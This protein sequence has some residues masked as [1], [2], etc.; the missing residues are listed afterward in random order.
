MAQS[1]GE[2]FSGMLN[3]WQSMSQPDLTGKESSKV[4]TDSLQKI[5]DSL[6]LVQANLC[7]LVSS[8]L[9][10]ANQLRLV[11]DLLLGKDSV[12]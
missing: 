3:L 9:G 7:E 6:D 10:I 4:L 11:E 2:V 1:H 12:T 8:S 5:Q